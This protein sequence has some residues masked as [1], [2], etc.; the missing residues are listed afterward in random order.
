MIMQNDMSVAGTLVFKGENEA[1]CMD[2]YSIW[3]IQG[4]TLEL[5]FWYYN[6]YHLMER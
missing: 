6:I 5:F 4:L 1:N 3:I 2:A